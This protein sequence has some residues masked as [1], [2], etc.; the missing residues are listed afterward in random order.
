MASKRNPS[1]MQWPA[2]FTDADRKVF[3]SIRVPAELVVDAGIRRATNREARNARL[4]CSGDMAGL[5]FPYIDPQSDSVVTCRVRRDN[6]EKDTDGKT[7][8]K[9]IMPPAKSTKRILYYPPNAKEKLD[10]PQGIC[11]VL[12]E[13]EKSALALTAWA[14]RR[15]LSDHMLF[16]AMGGCWSWSQNKKAMADF[17]LLDGCNVLVLLDTNVKS[18]PNVRDAHDALVAELRSRKCEVFTLSLPQMEGVNGPDDLL[19]QPNGDALMAS[20]FDEKALAI[21]APFSD[22]ALA[23]SFA[24][25]Q[26]DNLR[27]VKLW[28]Q[29]L[30]WR[31]QHW[32]G[33]GVQEAGR[34]AQDFCHRAASEC[35]KPSE[36]NRIRSSR[37]IEAVQ[38]EASKKKLLAATPDQWDAEK[39][40][41][42]TPQGT[43]DLHSGELRPASREDYC[44]KL[45]GVGPSTKRPTR[46]LQFLKEIAQSDRDLQA[47]LQRV[48]GYCLTGDT[49]EHALFFLHGTGANGKSVFVNALLGVLGDYASVAPMDVFTAT[50]HPQ[51]PTSIAALRG[52]RLVAATE[53]ED[54]NRWAEAKL[55][56][57]TGGTQITARFMR[58][59][60][61]TFSPQ[62]KPVISGNHKPKLRNVD[63]AMRRRIHLVPFNACFSKEKRDPKLTE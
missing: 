48:A 44:T 18:N 22:D 28:G 17:D 41:L 15:A 6:P 7:V 2:G 19:A 4:V 43:V 60:E 58:K 14:K 36:Q 25:E 52:A 51:H 21:I 35:A 12:V 55:K 16:I 8:A 32:K 9:Y 30:V 46:W 27:Y 39:W 53:T 24:E 61:F 50:N 1:T 40:L 3:Q 34:L 31:G 26:N 13:A 59:D 33:D 20:V 42:A 38:R 62:F 10:H 5:L 11:F 56:E 45:S 29:W 57:M 47:Y 23:T 37:T 54:G 63:D 49:S